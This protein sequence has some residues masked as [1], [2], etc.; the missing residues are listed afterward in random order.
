MILRRHWECQTHSRIASA[1][2]ADP[3]FLQ[4]V[5]AIVTGA[6]CSTGVS[7]A[8]SAEFTRNL[9]RSQRSCAPMSRFDL[10]ACTTGRFPVMDSTSASPL[11]LH[12]RSP[13]HA[14]STL[15]RSSSPTRF[16]TRPA[17]IGSIIVDAALHP[18]PSRMRFLHGKSGTV[19]VRSFDTKYLSPQAA[20]AKGCFRG[21]FPVISGCLD[22]MALALR[23]DVTVKSAAAGEDQ[24]AFPHRTHQSPPGSKSNVVSLSAAVLQPSSHL[25]PP[26]PCAAGVCTILGEPYCFHSRFPS[27]SHSTGAT[28]WLTARSLPDNSKLWRDLGS[29]PR[30]QCCKPPR[31]MPR[32]EDLLPEGAG[33]PDCPRPRRSLATEASG[34]ADR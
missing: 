21:H 15:K 27:W 32:W 13:S 8:L 30:D 4:T 34:R 6:L 26:P 18:E 20:Q 19:P 2:L 29:D 17:T 25:D 1:N 9:P 3:S 5:M 22:L 28:I 10:A 33:S 23:K 14:C 12:T 24:R 31:R 7:S 16:R 11:V